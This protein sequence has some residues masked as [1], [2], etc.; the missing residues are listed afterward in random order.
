MENEDTTTEVQQ[1]EAE[2]PGQE[3]GTDVQ[4]SAP[5][6]APRN[7]AQERIN[8]LTKKYRDEE[9][10][11]IALREQNAQLMAALTQSVTQISN[12][13]QQPAEPEMDPEERK[14]MD[15][16]LSP[17]QRELAEMRAQLAATGVR[18]EIQRIAK[19]GTPPEVIEMAAGT[20]AAWRKQGYRG[21]LKDALSHA[22]GEFILS[23]GEE[24][25]QVTT[26]RQS[27]N[28]S[29][30]TVQ[31]G[32]NGT[33]QRRTGPKQLS[34]AEIERM[35]PSDQAAYYRERLGDTEF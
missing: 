20:A 17:L 9:R 1:T 35:N 23:K 21:P 18:D 11:K 2:I 3:V 7:G 29:A 25:A 19:P 24:D 28:K 15:Y 16:F 4:T 14:R 26:Q 6:E 10:E 31:T 34:D 22:M 8:E 13:A 33:P 27:F 5:P 32:Q 30:S 12:R